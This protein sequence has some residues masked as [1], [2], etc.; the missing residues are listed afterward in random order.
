MA[1]LLLWKLSVAMALVDGRYLETHP[2]RQL[3]WAL[4]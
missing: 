1:Y 2:A 3:H 4:P